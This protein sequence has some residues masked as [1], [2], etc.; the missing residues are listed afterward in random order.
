MEIQSFLLGMGVVLLIASVVGGVVALVKV[1]KLKK[2]VDFYE[3]NRNSEMQ[4]VYHKFEDIGKGMD[5]R[6]DK[7]ENKVSSTEF[8]FNDPERIA[9]I[10]ELI[11][12]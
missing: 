4:N 10:K 5:S 9:R 12:K 3:R 2:E 6:L 11:S 7:F 8:L 1:G